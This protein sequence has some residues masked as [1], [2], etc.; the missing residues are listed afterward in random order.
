MTRIEADGPSIPY[1]PPEVSAPNPRQRLTI[2]T[3]PAPSGGV[4]IYTEAG[5]FLDADPRTEFDD[6]ADSG[7]TW[8]T[9]LYEKGFSIVSAGMTGFD[10]GHPGGGLFRP[11]DSTEYLDSYEYSWPERD[12]E[13]IVQK[14]RNLVTAGTVR[15]AQN[16]IGWYGSSSS[17]VCGL[18]LAL[19]LDR[20]RTSGSAQVQTTTLLRFCVA[21]EPPVWWPAYDQAAVP[22]LHFPAG[23]SGTTPAARLEDVPVELQADA[24]PLTWWNERVAA[25]VGLTPL[26]LAFDEPVESTNFALDPDGT[27]NLDDTLLT[28]HPYWHGLMLAKSKK[29]YDP[30][31]WSQ[32]GRLVV[33][34]GHELPPPDDDHDLTVTALFDAQMQPDL[35]GWILSE[36]RQQ[37]PTKVPVRPI[38]SR[39]DGT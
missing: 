13:W 33:T 2:F 30:T 11:Y 20:R 9:N 16:K 6:E 37:G 38:G 15:G 7:V 25:G 10:G 1:T 18:T 14:V 5:N 34:S 35:E 31:R 36:L 29:A 26:Y 22:A 24:S 17:A 12:A 32:I 8:V 21:I 19:G 27:P 28:V 3:P 39:R 23:G 4:L